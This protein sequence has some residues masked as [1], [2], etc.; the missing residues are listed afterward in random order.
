MSIAF[1][2]AATVVALGAGLST[3]SA[4]HDSGLHPSIA[5]PLMLLTDATSR[6]CN[7]GNGMAC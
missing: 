3:A 5:Q 6:M 7:A 1:R 4:F 2:L